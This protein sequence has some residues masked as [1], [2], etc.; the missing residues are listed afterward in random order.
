M[1]ILMN[2]MSLVGMLVILSACGPNFEATVPA[3]EVKPRQVSPWLAYGGPG[4][5]KFAPVVHIN[6]FNVANLKPAWVFRT[7]DVSTVFQTTPILVSGQLVFCSPYNR[8]FSL[9]PFT[10]GELWQ[11]DAKIDRDARVS[12][13]FNCR[14]VAA[15][16][17]APSGH[18][19]E[20]IFMAT[21]DARLI[22]L[23]SKTGQRC[24][25]FGT[26]GEVDLSSGV[27]KLRHPGEYQVTSPPA[28]AGGVVVVGSAVRDGS[29]VDAP[30]GVVRGYDI[31]T[32]ALVWAF[33][34]APPGFDYANRP[35]SAA[36]YALGTPNVWSVMSVDDA[37]GLVF[38]P[39]GNPSPDYD[40][41]INGDL[42][43]YGSAVVALHAATGRVAWHFNTVVNDLWDFDVPSQP[44]LAEVTIRGEEI[45]VVIQSTKMGFIFVLHR[46]TG[47]PVID[48]NYLEVP[49][50]GPLAAQLSPTQPFP[51]DVFQV[52]RRYQAGDSLLGLCDGLD[53]Q[54][55]IGP[56][57]TPITEQWT[58][59]LPSNMGATNW[60][61]IAVDARRGLIAVHTNAV[62][63]RTKLIRRSEAVD[64]LR[65]LNDEGAS[66]QQKI[67]AREEM[68]VRFDLPE[69]V[70]LAQQQ[71]VEF[72]M[73]RHIYR[74]PYVGAPCA[75]LPMA[76]MMV[77]DIA[78]QKQIWRRPHGSLRDF[79]GL[80]VNTG[81]PG[82]GGPLITQSGLVFIGGAAE[83]AIR[84][85]DLTTGEQLWHHRLPH[86]GN[87][88]PMTYEVE[89]NHGKH[90]F[91]VIA[92][93]GDARTGVGGVGDYLVAFS[94][95]H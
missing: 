53:A 24:H 83:K 57:Y 85:Y 39:T 71:G 82:V 36:G 32:G 27:G 31:R 76:E 81:V 84:A 51:P 70:E 21:N 28:V 12:N 75:G 13:E 37:R 93:G 66:D 14:G 78:E 22:A 17:V 15:G 23:D 11:F 60:G 41:S 47:E 1:K 44:V 49:V 54:S 95:P 38:L 6:K 48:V 59:G 42:N 29:R 43:Y 45:P 89:T 88:T 91:L 50:S 34:L 5:Q 4:G 61:G 65:V 18:C 55:V 9:D 72:L 19:G 94:L 16:L 79:A 35:V 26:R 92:A 74:D 52:S 68:R 7:G 20:R 64:L 3:G 63:F 77:L 67:H 25:H 56:I 69:D 40:R 33:D 80:P 58:V 10:G 2:I 87:A 8:V 90:Q 46:E 30:S 62:P 86:P 73:A